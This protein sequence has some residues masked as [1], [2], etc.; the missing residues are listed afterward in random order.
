[1]DLKDII[2][3]VFNLLPPVIAPHGEIYR[4]GDTSIVALKDGY[5]LVETPTVPPEHPDRKHR[6]DTVPDFAAFLL[7]HFKSDNAEILANQTAIVAVSGPDWDRDEVTCTLAPDPTWRDWVRAFGVEMGQKDL[8]RFV[9]QHRADVEK[10]D[11]LLGSLRILEVSASGA[12]KGHLDERGFYTAV[13]SQKNTEVS[14]K[15]PPTIKLS[16]PVY[17]GSEDRYEVDV[18][19]EIDVVDG[20]LPT[21]TLR[22]TDLERVKVAAL[23]NEVARLRSLLGDGWLVTRGTMA[24][25]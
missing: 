20:K 14:V 25:G 19:L 15:L 17:L 13:V 11:A 22:P 5:K 7:R 23:D 21:F 1:M 3:I 4:K 2:G 18:D 16:V 9:Q 6:I 24:L 12:V 10:G 8:Y